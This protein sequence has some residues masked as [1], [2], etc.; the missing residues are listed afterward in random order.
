MINSVAFN[1]FNSGY[2]SSG[3][4]LRTQ[5]WG[6]AFCNSFDICDSDLFYEED[7]AVACRMAWNKYVAEVES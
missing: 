2:F 5:R 1:V 4:A 3:D 7:C 6:Q